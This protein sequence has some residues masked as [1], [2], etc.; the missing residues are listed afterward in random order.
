MERSVPIRVLHGKYTGDRRLLN[1]L[2]FLCWV[3]WNKLFEF[4]CEWG[5]QVY[6]ASTGACL[7]S[8]IFLLPTIRCIDVNVLG[9]VNR[10][11]SSGD[12]R[13]Y[14]RRLTR[15]LGR[16]CT[17][18]H[19]RSSTKNISKK[20]CLGKHP[21]VYDGNATKAVEPRPHLIDR[22]IPPLNIYVGMRGLAE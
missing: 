17:V 12:A 20:L 16:F 3:R 15:G 1:A 6:F 9:W 18:R 22:D 7:G 5:R 19:A 14:N 11:G 10:F 13:T 2:L 4:R 8:L 21:P